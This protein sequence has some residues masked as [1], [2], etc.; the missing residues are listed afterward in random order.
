MTHL[1]EVITILLVMLALTVMVCIRCGVSI[2]TYFIGLLSCIWMTLLRPWQR[3]MQ[4]H[5]ILSS[6]QRCLGPLICSY[7]TKVLLLWWLDFIS[8]IWLGWRLLYWA[9]I[10]GGYH[11]SRRFLP[12]RCWLDLSPNLRWWLLDVLNHGE[13]SAVDLVWWILLLLSPDWHWLIAVFTWLVRDII[14]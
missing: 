11:L 10:G 6:N 4:S 1:L 13:G 3:R 8:T 12:K 5:I 7:W 14:L 9:H 2:Q